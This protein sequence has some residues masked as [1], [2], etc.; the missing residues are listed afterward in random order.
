MGAPISRVAASLYE[1]SSFE[2]VNV[3]DHGVAVDTHR[4]GK[5]LLGLSVIS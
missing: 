4:V 3:S 1:S 2:V 5:L